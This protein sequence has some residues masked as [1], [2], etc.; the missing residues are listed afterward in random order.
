MFATVYGLLLF[1]LDWSHWTAEM[2]YLCVC[3]C[4]LL[5]KRVF[6]HSVGMV[7][8][9]ESLKSF[10]ACSLPERTNLWAMVL[11]STLQVHVE[12]IGLM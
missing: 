5:A 7:Q 2:S 3:T 6:G 1:Q 12:V 8:T 9:I 10:F 4:S 11:T